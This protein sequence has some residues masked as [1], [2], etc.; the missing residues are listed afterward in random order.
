MITSTANPRV[1]YVRSLYDKRTRYAERRI[2]VE[3]LRLLEEVL[4][5]GVK[6]LLVFYDSEAVQENP[7][8]QALLNAMPGVEQVEVTDRVLRAM[9]DT[10]SPQGIVAVV[11]FP[12]EPTRVTGDLA[13]VL[14]GLQDPGNVGTILRTA[15]AAW[16][17]S[18]VATRDTVDPFNPKVVRAGMGAQFRLGLLWDRTWDEIEALTRGRVRILAVA[19]DGEPCWRADWKH[20]AALIISSEAHGASPEAR[21]LAQVRVSIPMKPGV[22]SLNAAIAAAV[23]MFEARRRG[24]ATRDREP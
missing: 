6:P 12:P 5:S 7:R 1:K 22:E 18:V 23:L 15:E 11:P 21:R 20:P 8:A 10:P 4:R 19:R 3:G 16:V 24:Q 9:A 2:P 13:L 14:E 17:E